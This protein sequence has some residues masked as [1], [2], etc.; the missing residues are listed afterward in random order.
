MRPRLAGGTPDEVLGVADRQEA[1]ADEHHD[2]ETLEKRHRPRTPDQEPM[3]AGDIG[4][5]PGT[6]G[7]YCPRQDL[8]GPHAGERMSWFSQV[9]NVIGITAQAAGQGLLIAAEAVLPNRHPGD[10]RVP[11]GDGTTHHMG[12]APHPG[13]MA[14]GTQF[15]I[16]IG[17][18]T[19][20]AESMRYLSGEEAANILRDPSINILH[21]A[22]YN[23]PRSPEELRQAGMDRYDKSVRVMQIMGS[24]LGIG[25]G[26]GSMLQ[27]AEVGAE[28]GF[29]IAPPWG[30][31]LGAVAGIA[32][33]GGVAY[34][35]ED[36]RDGRYERP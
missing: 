23:G 13:L 20:P 5:T 22:E 6:A 18:R 8:P 27:G 1:P 29:T 9:T 3:T 32:I 28:L 19:I 21:A 12:C 11:L 31:I 33:S 15:G 4:A 26:L 7:R 30:A 14:P 17:G 24:G 36:V 34:I 35:L 16:N 25:T 10:I 2:I